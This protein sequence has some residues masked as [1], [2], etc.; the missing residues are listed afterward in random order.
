MKYLLIPLM[1]ILA[2]SK[3]LLQSHYSQSKVFRTCDGV[4]YNCIMFTASALFLIP[5]LFLNKVSLSTLFFGIISGVLSVIFQLAYMQ[6]FSRGKPVLVTT[7]NNF[8]MFIPIAASCVLFGEKFGIY[9][10]IVLAFA[11]ISVILITIKD[12]KT[13]FKK[14]RSDDTG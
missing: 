12:K 1:C 11:A 10:G 7:V 14:P 9:R 4:L 5:S 3:V 6:A 13:D 2:T 8:S